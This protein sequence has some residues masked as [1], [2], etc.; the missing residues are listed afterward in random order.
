MSQNNFPILYL[1]ID[2]AKEELVPDPN[3]LPRVPQVVNS[4]AGHRQILRALQRAY[5]QARVHVILEAT[6]G[7]EQPLVEALR[8]AEVLVSVVLPGRVRKFAQALG[9]PKT[10][11]I[12]A[13]V[14]SLYGATVQPA[15][16]KA[17]S[18]TEQRLRALHRRRRQLVQ[19]H[20]QELNRDLGGVDCPLLRA[21]AEQVLAALKKQIA[22]LESALRALQK[23]DPLLDA[24]VQT[25]CAIQSVGPTTALAV[26]ATVPELGSLNRHE[27]ASLA[28]LAPINR[29]SGQST[30]RRFIG[31]G[32]PAARH[33]LYMAAVCAARCN[34]ILQPLYQRLLKNGKPP[35][36]ALTALMRQLLIH[37]N[38]KLKSLL[39]PPLPS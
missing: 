28:G 36:V 29:D 24:K 12:D 21:S 5:P 34:P 10:D 1:G 25:L 4:A 39:Q 9:R 2:V 30:G 27:V 26:L 37:M 14:L 19:M 35:K 18:E 20:T 31:G 7:Y 17:L 11:P 13:A 32:R 23:A 3:R 33:A 6:G 8:A 15:P 16:T 22:A 38:S